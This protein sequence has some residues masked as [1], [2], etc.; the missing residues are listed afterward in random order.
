V[1]VEWNDQPVNIV[2]YTKVDVAR[3]TLE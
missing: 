3:F 2:P 1:K